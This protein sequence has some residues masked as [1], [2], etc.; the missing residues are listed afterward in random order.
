PVL[1]VFLLGGMG[2]ALLLFALAALIPLC[3]Q[4]WPS[5]TSRF[6]LRQR[7]GLAVYGAA[8]LSSTALVF[9]LVSSTS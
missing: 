1:E 7:A 8:L 2:V 4:A 9:L 3:C 6:L 5:G